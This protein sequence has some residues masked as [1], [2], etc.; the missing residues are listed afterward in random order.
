MPWWRDVAKI[1]VGKSVALIVFVLDFK[2]CLNNVLVSAI[3]DLCE[4]SAYL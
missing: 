4:Y 3:L 2:A 1:V